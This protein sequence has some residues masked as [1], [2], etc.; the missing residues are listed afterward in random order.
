MGIVALELFEEFV[1][2]WESTVWFADT[3]DAVDDELLEAIVADEVEQAAW[4][5]VE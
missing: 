2:G 3:G 5:F 1:R 4:E